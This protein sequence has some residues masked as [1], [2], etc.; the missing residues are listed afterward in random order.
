MQ[1]KRMQVK[2]QRSRDSLGERERYALRT[3]VD[4]PARASGMC[5][6][7]NGDSGRKPFALTR[8]TYVSVSLNMKRGCSMAE[9]ELER[10]KRELERRF[11]ER[12][13]ELLKKNQALSREIARRK[14]AE[15]KV[16]EELCKFQ[17]LYDVAVAMTT[18][19]SLDENLLLVVEKNRELLQADTSF[20]ALC[21]EKKQYIYMH[22][23]SGIRT[24]AF[25]KVRLP[26]GAGL[27]GKVAATSEPYI[28][29]N[30]YLDVE[31][32]IHD[33]VMAEGLFSGLAVPIRIGKT[34]LGVLYA[35]NRRRTSFSESDLDT[36]SLMGNLAA[37]EITRKKSEKALRNARNELAVRV[38]ERTAQLSG[39]NQE[40]EREIA[41][42]IHA[43]RLAL[44]N[45]RRF[46]TIFETAPDCIFIKDRAMRYVV[47]NPAM[48]QLLEMPAPEIVGLT[49]RQLFGRKVAEH[50]MNVCRRVLKGETIEEENTR[51]IKGIPMTFLDKRAPMRDAHGKIIGIC[52][53]SRNITERK[54]T[55]ALT[56]KVA[57]E[58]PSAVMRQTIDMVLAATETEALT[59]LTGE[60]GSGKDFI[61]RFIHDNSGRSSN[62]FFSINCATVAPELA[63]S[64]LFGHESGAF[65]GARRRKRGLLELA[66]GGTLLL[67]E[68]GELSVNL[69]AKLLSFLDTRT[70]TRV[71][72]GDPVRVDARIIAA[73]NRDLEKEVVA[74]KFRA[75][76]FYRLNVLAI[77]IP[78]L[79][80]RIEDLPIL[81]KEIRAQLRSELQVPV[82]PEIPKNILD[83]WAR[84]RWP[85]NVRELRNV[86]ERAMILSEGASPQI[87]TQSAKAANHLPDSLDW[88]LSVGFPPELPLMDLANDLKRYVISEALKRTGGNKADAARLLGISRDALRGQIKRLRL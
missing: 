16:S 75:D 33:I 78:P 31:P 60:S 35:F 49:D 85:G 45:E 17:A 40:L 59:L 28:V 26:M 52:G 10:E 81:V 4:C 9:P 30:Y 13:K 77:Q 5:I 61:A 54:R 74:G 46:R 66:E 57:L 47:V 76:L 8:R 73:T 63:E 15:T 50:L 2:L 3:G 1:A 29:E 72:G 65:T 44:E 37:I 82:G 12:T 42:R 62:P 87:H 41:E 27:G 25:K 70:F 67:N 55:W 51:P 53:I 22:T 68:I 56:R 20:I 86:L 11:R 21:D 71:G 64:E 38:D 79:R 58:Y 80:E 6:G 36:M 83:R 48:E 23:L 34:D 69:Q 84:Y 24:E 14:E 43:E 19:R 32:I 39:V 7:P 18:E 88:S